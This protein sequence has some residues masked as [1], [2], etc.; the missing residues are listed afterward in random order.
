MPR[1][2]EKLPP[3]VRRRPGRPYEIFYPGPDGKRVQETLGTDLREAVR[4]RAE[5]IAEVRAGTWVRADQRR[6]ESLT[7]DQ[8]ADVWL[9]KRRQRPNPPRTLHDEVA[10]LRDHLRP[11]LGPV[12]LDAI[13]V[14]HVRRVLAE[15]RS[16]TSKRT[17]RPLAA[18]TITNTFGTLAKCLRD[19]SKELGRQGVAWVPPVDQLDDDEIPVLVDRPREGFPREEL[20]SLLTDARIPDERRV[21]WALLGLTGMRHNEGAGLRWSDVDFRA[22]PLARILL[23]QQAGGLRLKEDKR[24]RG[25]SREIPV[26]PTLR[27]VL[28]QW[29]TKGFAETFG[30]HPRPSDYV[31]PRPGDVTLH[32]LNRTS[33]GQLRRD[34]VAL[35]IPVRC[36]HTL[37]NTFATLASVDAP[38]LEAVV[39]SITHQTTPVRGAFRTYVATQSRWL[40]KC[41]AVERLDVVL[42]RHAQV[43]T[44]PKAAAGGLSAT[45]TPEASADGSAAVERARGAVAGRVVDGGGSEAPAGGTRASSKGAARGRSSTSTRDG[46]R[47]PTKPVATT[48]EPRGE[49]LREGARDDADPRTPRVTSRVTPGEGSAEPERSPDVAG[50]SAVAHAVVRPPVGGAVF[51]PQ[52]GEAE[53]VHENRG[54]VGHASSLLGF[55]TA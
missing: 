21:F 2:P 53:G 20:E 41:A 17:G 7:F 49:G 6:R 31:S 28:E 11:V 4:I 3:G 15:L 39:A 26:H 1:R 29:R 33:L 42:V 50:F 25:L 27:A 9:D 22:E 54:R 14:D 10:R 19:A 5:R 48:D 43:V 52:G 30:R 34:C 47:P 45:E 16:K 24:G 32:R 38:E 8:W 13:T 46:S 55:E 36:P 51:E 18:N 37:R 40:A 23:T 12:R 44:L 35:G